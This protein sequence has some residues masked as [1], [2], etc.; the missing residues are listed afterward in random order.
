MKEME[1]ME[2]EPEPAVPA[3][4]SP[5]P[6]DWPALNVVTDCHWLKTG[7]RF[8]WRKTEMAAALGVTVKTV[9]N[10]MI[11]MDREGLISKAGRWEWTVTELGRG[12]IREAES[13]AV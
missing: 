8:G 9:Y 13:Y 11:R 7:Q 2:G 5:P 10:Q 12:V 6:V 1:A 4:P 3:P